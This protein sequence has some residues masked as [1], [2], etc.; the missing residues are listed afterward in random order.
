MIIG[1]VGSLKGYGAVDGI[2]QEHKLIAGRSEL[3]EGINIF[4][5]I[6]NRYLVDIQSRH[7]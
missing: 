2:D 6:L 3:I 1:M 7:F 5:K 4:S